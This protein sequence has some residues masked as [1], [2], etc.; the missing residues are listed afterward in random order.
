[1]ESKGGQV[2]CPVGVLWLK[3][4]GGGSA[5]SISDRLLLFDKSS[6]EGRP[7][8]GDIIKVQTELRQNRAIIAACRVE[9]MFERRYTG[10]R[11]DREVRWKC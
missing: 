10:R 1:M 11:V 4:D 6:D 7:N 9:I 3:I 5:G 8:D 2:F